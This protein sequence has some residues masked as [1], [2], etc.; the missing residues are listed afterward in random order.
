MTGT[1]LQIIPPVHGN[2]AAVA[3]RLPE[4]HTNASD[5]DELLVVWLKSHMDGS[6]H[7]VRA[8]SRIGRRFIQGLSARGITLRS[9]K[10]DDVQ[11]ALEAMRTTEKGADAS[12]A[13]M[14]TYVAAVKSLLTFA[15]T[16]GFTRF[17]AAPL[18]KLKRAP[19]RLAEKLISEV[20]V[21][22][23]VRHARPGRD[24]TLLRVAYYGALRVAELVGLTWSQVIPRDSGEVQ[25][26]VLGK[27][28]KTRNVLLP[29]AIGRDLLALR[30]GM[31]SSERVFAISERRVAYIVKAAGRRAG[32]EREVSPNTFRHAHASHALDN[33]ASIALVSSTLGHADLKTTSVYAHA[34][35][36]DSSSRFLK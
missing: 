10:L 25:L 8:Y 11:A 21:Q 16:V 22:L 6:A 19:R 33:G 26:A 36:G 18:I 24:Q 2:I 5:D 20:E 34:K 1:E 35:P 32:I 29:A 31:S 13:T 17:N 28:D 9:A 12:P 3:D 14:Q 15:H 4:V 23:I 7:T 30:E 27:G